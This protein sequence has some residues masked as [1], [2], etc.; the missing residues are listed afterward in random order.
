MAVRSIGLYHLIV[1]QRVGQ[2]NRLL[3]AIFLPFNIPMANGRFVRL[4]KVIGN[5]TKTHHKG[6][7]NVIGLIFNSHR[8]SNSQLMWPYTNINIEAQHTMHLTTE[9]YAMIYIQA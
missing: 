1:Q 7:L 8:A 9:R 3:T 6:L 2:V 5:Y 4:L